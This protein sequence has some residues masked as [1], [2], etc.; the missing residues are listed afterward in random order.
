MRRRYFL[1]VLLILVCLVC[2]IGAQA[3]GNG[4]RLAYDFNDNSLRDTFETVFPQGQYKCGFD[5]PEGEYVALADYTSE[6]ATYGDFAYAGVSNDAN[7]DD[8]IYNGCFSAGYI[9]SVRNGEYLELRDCYAVPSEEF[10]SKYYMTVGEEDISSFDQYEYMLKVG[11]Q[12]D[13]LPGE[14]KLTA[15]S[16]GGDYTYFI[17]S[18]SYMTLDNCSTSDQVNNSGYLTVSDGEYL[19]IRGCTLQ[20]GIPTITATPEPTPEPTAEPTPEPTAEPTPEPTPELTAEP[21]SEPMEEATD[22]VD[23]DN[24]TV[25]PTENVTPEPTATNEPVVY[26]ELKVGDKGEKVKIL[27]RKLIS[28]GYLTGGADGDFGGKTKAAVKEFQMANGLEITGIAD[29]AM[30]QI[31][32]YVEPI[33]LSSMVLTVGSKGEEVKAAQQ[34]LIELNYLS[35]KADDDFGN[36]TASAVKDYQTNAGLPA[37]GE[38]DA[39]TMNSMMSEDA[40]KAIV[41]ESLNYKELSRNPAN[42]EGIHFKFNGVIGWTTENVNDAT[43]YTTV[44][45]GVNTKGRYDDDVY[46]EYDREEGE[47]RYLE[48]DKVVIYGEFIGLFSYNT[49]S[50]TTRTIPRFELEKIELR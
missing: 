47:T 4:E 36:K 32:F 41:Y 49:V 17:Y 34:R 29:D 21:T 39:T 5:I 8:I 16:S 13:I 2:G 33:D 18:S 15:V 25:S 26:E 38:I 1:G 20:G 46:I 10:Y 7:S 28:K 43:P 44:T 45:M 11:D 37:T 50:N 19:D 27:Q 9:I 42:Y 12:Y 35:G 31:L 3:E 23:V 14:Y 24:E 6:S 48:G 22:N 40:P 30:Q